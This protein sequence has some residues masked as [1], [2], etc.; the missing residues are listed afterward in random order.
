MIFL[1]G[2]GLPTLASLVRIGI[3]EIFPHS[4]ETRLKP[5]AL[6]HLDLEL[7]AGSGK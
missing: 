7:Q 5:L 3:G 6:L 4:S 1:G 2:T